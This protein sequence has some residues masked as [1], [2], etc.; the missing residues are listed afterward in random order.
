FM[1]VRFSAYVS[2]VEGWVLC[3]GGLQT[4]SDPRGSSGK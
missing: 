4:P 2:D 3:G 1:I